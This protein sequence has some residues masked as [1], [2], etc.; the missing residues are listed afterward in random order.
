M[1][2]T[3]QGPG[4]ADL[5]R[6]VREYFPLQLEACEELLAF[7]VDM[8]EADPWRGKPIR[9]SQV[10]D[11]VIA[12]ES[13]RGLK[14]YRASLDAALGGYGPQAAMMNRALFEGM[15]TA[16]WACANPQLASERFSQH[17][18][19][20]RG[21]WSKRYLASGVI[22]Q[23]LPDVPGPEEQRKLD[24]LFG[25]WGDKLWCGLPLHELVAA[26]ED[27]WE[28]GARLK[29]FFVIA[30]ATN[31]EVQ[32]TT[33]RSLLQPVLGD[34]VD[35]LQVD[36]GP[37]LGGVEQALH[38]AMWTYAHLLKAAADYFEIDGRKEI[39]PLLARWEAAFM[40]IHPDAARVTERNDPCPC[41]SGKKFKRCHG[42]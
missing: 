26:I 1:S 2:N 38:G 28:E 10:A 17:Q 22:E 39:K 25:P 6:L 18:R 21:L 31:N 11:T 30:H 23:P 42:R 24:R 9:D 13:A 3:R 4:R 34:T 41:G 16:C 19:H 40:P 15:A 20:H 35:H 29:G 36:A 33:T 8:M 27:Q 14:T 37:S 5:E 7:A 12:A 32:H